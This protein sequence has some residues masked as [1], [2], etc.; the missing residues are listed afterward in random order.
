MRIS[1]EW[2]KTMVDVPEDPQELVREFVR[3]G[4]EVQAAAKL[5]AVV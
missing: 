5:V 4:T 3:T 1:Y 2:L